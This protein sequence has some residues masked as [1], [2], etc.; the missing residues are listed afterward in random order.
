MQ[1]LSKRNTYTPTNAPQVCSNCD[2][3]LNNSKGRNSVQSLKTFDNSSEEDLQQHKAG[4]DTSVQ[5]IVYVLNMRGKPLMPTTQ[6][7]ARK[8]LRCKKAKVVKRFPFTIQLL[9]ATGEC[10]QE[11]TLGIDTGYENVGISVVSKTKELFSVNLKLRTDIKKK[12]SEK[13]MYRKNRRS[14]LW[15]RKPRFLNRGKK[16]WLPPSIQ[17]RLDSHIRIIDKIKTF[18]PITK[19]IAETAN[20]DIQK[21]NNPDIEGKG[22]QEGRQK[23]FENVKSYVLNRDDY[24]CQ[25]C[26]KK[27]L[28]L[29]VHHLESR[30]TGTNSPDNLITL[31]KECHNLYHQGEFKL[32]IKKSKSFKAETFMSIIRKRLLNILDCEETFGYETKTK[33]KELKLEKSHVND[34]FC[35]AK[36]KDQERSF[37]QNI[38][39]KRKNNRKLQVQRNG[40]KPAIRKQ[41]YKIQPYDLV[42]I[43]RKEYISKGIH[44]NGKRLRILE[45]GKRKSVLVKKVENVF[46][47]GTFVYI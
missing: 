20:F 21:I 40:F 33:R 38:T 9:I 17:H 18:L 1:K 24:K 32:K 28:V 23:D 37:I 47:T 7:K 5:N 6:S 41:R 4:F 31:C 15:H 39:Q 11:V 36:G 42:K 8:L 30:M 46:N 22:Y 45:N 14:K 44:C 26:N 12:L 34:A 19:V 3:V 16:G 27:N 43:D 2:S 35:I 25:Y 13:S 29:N 10:K